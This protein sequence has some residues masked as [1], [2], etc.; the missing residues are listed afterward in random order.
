MASVFENWSAIARSGEI[1]RAVISV[2]GSIGFHR[3]LNVLVD[4]WSL[5]Q[6]WLVLGI[7]R[8]RRSLLRIVLRVHLRLV[9]VVQNLMRLA[10]Y[11]IRFRLFRAREF[12]RDHHNL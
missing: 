11:W 9:Y 3:L 10:G 12:R 6:S 8:K 1:R 7:R 4:L 2:R 5:R